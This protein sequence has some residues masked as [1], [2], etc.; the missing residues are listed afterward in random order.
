[1]QREQNY[2]TFQSVGVEHEYMEKSFKALAVKV[3]ETRK[4]KEEEGEGEE[5]EKPNP[6]SA[7]T[8][9]SVEVHDWEKPELQ[10][11]DWDINYL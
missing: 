11:M 7:R 1:M 2:W 8:L 3:G 4:K 10:E 6:A 5:E 9:S